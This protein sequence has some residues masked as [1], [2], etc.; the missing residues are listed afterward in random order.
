MDPRSNPF[1][2]GAGI[3]PPK[4]AGRRD[5]TERAA[6]ALDRIR[7]RAAA[8]SL[9]FYGLRGVGKT[10]LL[11]RVRHDAEA[12]GILAARMEAPEARSLPGWLAPGLRALLMRL[13]RGAAAK[14]TARRALSAL[15]SFAKALKFR[16]D[17]LQIGLEF[18]PE[19]GLA[20]SGDLETD[21]TA[22]LASV[23]T[24]A[25]ERNMAVVLFID[26]LQ[27]VREEELAAL[28]GALHSA[29][30]DQ[31]PITMM[32]AGLPQL[33]GRAGRAKSYAERLFEFVPMDRLDP[34]A[35]EAA[36]RVPAAKS[37]VTFGG[38]AISEILRQTLGYPYFLQEWGKHCWNLADR[39]PIEAKDARRATVQALAELDASFF[40]VR[41]DR[42]TPS[43]KRYLRAMAELGPGPHRS[44]NIADRLGKR[45]TTVAP[46]RSALIAK[47]MIYSPAHGDTA[48]TVPLFDG[49]MKRTMPDWT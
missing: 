41:F 32:A 20:D 18:E 13:S 29:S 27:Y 47:G 46:V 24:A 26:E 4:L 15:Y 44:G 38:A 33:V 37:N 21:L 22:L 12:R 43:E 7:A 28:I 31:L 9:I 16:Y 14:A 49:F 36:L 1:A 23:G 10:V 11:N 17:D 34:D 2:P 5:L 19:P 30:Q 40:R 8:R 3:P 6:I 25:A 39:P 35:A 45:V 42:L 48:F